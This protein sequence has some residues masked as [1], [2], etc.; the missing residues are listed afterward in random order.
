V[1]LKLKIALFWIVIVGNLLKDDATLLSVGVNSEQTAHIEVQSVDPINF[2][3][4][5]LNNSPAI[6]SKQNSSYKMPE[7]LTVKVESGN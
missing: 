3:L 7:V 5:L 6:S 2:P 1:L 4:K